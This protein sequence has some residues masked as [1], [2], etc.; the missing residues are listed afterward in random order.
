MCN[1]SCI[2]FG[3]KNLS[4]GEVRGKSVI[5]VGSLDVNGSL[6][7]TIEAFHPLRYIGV[8]L[9]AGPGVDEI[10]SAHNLLERFGNEAFDLLVS[11]EVLE[12]VRD[13]RKAIS[14]FKNILKPGGILLVTTRSKGFGYHGHP[15]DFWRYDS[16]DMQII[17][18]DFVIEIIEPDPLEPGVFV[19]A[20]KPDAF[21]EV[22]LSNYRLCSI[23]TGRRTSTISAGSIFLYNARSKSRESLSRILPA[24]VKSLIKEKILKNI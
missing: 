12:H 1:R 6:R 18:S 4:E 19:K 9:Q 14:N 16:E 5:E 10:C 15:F 24:S 23:L 21:S 13:W 2:D 3:T 8:D 20:R 22:D 17:F 11:T 7:H